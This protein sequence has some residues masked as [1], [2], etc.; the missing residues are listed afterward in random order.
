MMRP[1][2]QRVAGIGFVLTVLAAEVLKGDSPSPTGPTEEVVAFFERRTAILAGAVAHMGALCLLALL[3]AAVMPT[4]MP[5]K[6]VAGRLARL[7]SPL[8]LVSL[9]LYVFLTA[10]LAYGAAADAG[11]VTARALWEIRFVSETF[12][13]VPIAL[14]VGAVAVVSRDVTRTW[15][16]VTSAVIAL[17]SLVGGAALARNGFFA[18]DGGYSFL[19]FWLLPIWV[20]A[21]AFVTSDSSDSPGPA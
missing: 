13:N 19:L 2:L 20:V 10:A 8:L 11:P 12:L 5:E 21:T 17:L 14:V 7:G 6:S 18:P 3:L 15:Y 16:T 1:A 9:T 4:L